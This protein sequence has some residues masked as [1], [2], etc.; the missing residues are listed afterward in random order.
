MFSP[1]CASATYGSTRMSWRKSLTASRACARNVFPATDFNNPGMHH[2][3]CMTTICQDAR[4]AH[5][6][7]SPSHTAQPNV[8]LTNLNM[9]AHEQSYLEAES[10]ILNPYISVIH[11]EVA[12]RCLSKG[13]LLVSN[14]WLGTGMRFFGST[15]CIVS[16]S[17]PRV[18]VMGLSLPRLGDLPILA[19]A[20]L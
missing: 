2:D 11:L 20:I 17:I 13:D 15:S 12:G 3:T 14:R 16:N 5:G 1:A 6:A 8:T 7:V 9:T 10:S 4:T 19:A 18:L